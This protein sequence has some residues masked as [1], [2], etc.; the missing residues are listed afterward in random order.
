MIIPP[1]DVA[2]PGLLLVTISSD[3]QNAEY[4]SIG[5][6]YQR[7]SAKTDDD[8]IQCFA[9]KNMVPQ[10]TERFIFVVFAVL[11]YFV[12]PSQG[13]LGSEGYQAICVTISRANSEHLTSVAPSIWRARS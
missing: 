8:P 12:H 13:G 9:W 4:I 11:N 10:L 5:V 2:H 1:V 3:A 7:V 6:A